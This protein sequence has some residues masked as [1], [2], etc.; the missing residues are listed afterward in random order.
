[1]EDALAGCVRAG[2]L[3]QGEICTCG[4]R[5][6]V[7]ES[8]YERFCEDFC[9]RVRALQVGAPDAAQSFLGAVVSADHQRKILSYLALARDL[10]G[11]VRVGGGV[12]QLPAP[13][14]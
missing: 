3:N 1:W 2:F 11:T 10:G 14:D 6:L 8:V 4:S 9:Q 7:E 13:Y 12:P 5:I